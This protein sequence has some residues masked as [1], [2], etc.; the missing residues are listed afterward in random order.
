MKVL[1]TALGIC[2]LLPTSVILLLGW[3]LALY[4]RVLCEIAAA[5][6]DVAFKFLEG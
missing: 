1:K 4:A 2:I 3:C 6:A 5:L